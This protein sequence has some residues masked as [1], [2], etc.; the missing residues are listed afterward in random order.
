MGAWSITITPALM[1][2]DHGL[3]MPLAVLWDQARQVYCLRS[4][5]IHCMYQA[6]SNL[7]NL[8]SRTASST[9]FLC[10]AGIICWDSC[11]PSCLEAPSAWHWR[12][13]AFALCQPLSLASQ[14]PGHLQVPQPCGALLRAAAPAPSV[15]L[16]LPDLLSLSWA[17]LQWIVWAHARRFAASWQWPMRTPAL[18]SWTTASS[19][20]VW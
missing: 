7:P 15:L 16:M 5:G 19:P 3:G 14:A 20:R 12:P 17:L 1:D 2:G 9:N 4:N 10:L 6:K 18:T 11:R 8:Q 13:W